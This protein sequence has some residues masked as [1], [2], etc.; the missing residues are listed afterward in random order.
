MESV[1]ELNKLNGNNGVLKSL[2]VGFVIFN[3][4]VFLHK[5]QKD[6]PSAKQ[7]YAPF[8]SAIE[9]NCLL[10]ILYIFGNFIPSKLSV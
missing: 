5:S 1:K 7:E 3:H 4:I 8:C 6:Y 2:L 10:S 9:S